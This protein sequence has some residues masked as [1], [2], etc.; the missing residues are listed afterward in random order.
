LNPRHAS[1]QLIVAYVLVEEPILEAQVTK[2]FPDPFDILK[3]HP[4]GVGFDSIDS[5]VLIRAPELEVIRLVLPAGHELRA[6]GVVS[7]MVT[8]QCTEGVVEVNATNLKRRLVAGDL[9]C[10]PSTES[11]LVRAI[12]DA[13]LLVTTVRCPVRYEM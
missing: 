5:A 13:I 1:H 4:A 12:E 3:V 11:H 2:F 10:F 9:I 7:G 6:E 8:M